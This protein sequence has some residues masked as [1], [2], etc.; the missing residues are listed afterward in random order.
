MVEIIIETFNFRRD[1][2]LKL[3]LDIPNFSNGF[4]LRGFL[5]W[6]T[7]VDKFFKY[8]KILEEKIFNWLRI[9]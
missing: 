2:E 9:Y 5:D 4:D 6:V 3:N 1:T 7:D 8:I